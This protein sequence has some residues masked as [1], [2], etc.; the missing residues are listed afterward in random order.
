MRI[1]LLGAPGSGKGT[2]GD[3]ITRH[4]GFPKISTGDLL[5]EAAA[6]GTPLGEIAKK[7]MQRGELV[8]DELVLEMVDRRIQQDDCRRGYVLDGFPRN[9]PQS[10]KLEALDQTQEVVIEIYLEDDIVIKR[11]SAR[12]ICSNCGMIYN[13]LVK[14]PEREY[15]CDACGGKLIQRD[16]DKPEVIKERLDVYHKQTEPLVDYYR[17]RGV[18]HRVNGDNAIQ[19]V[20][21]DVCRI[22]DEVLRAEE[23]QSLT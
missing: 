23:S 13:L 11:L 5:R 20:S 15:V 2:Q 1:I 22:L 10:Q 14:V 8:K 4:Y 7:A 17:N 16:D 6:A 3:M 21:E 12:R 19:S 18:F 9:I